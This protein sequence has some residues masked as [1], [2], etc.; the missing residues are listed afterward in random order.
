MVKSIKLNSSKAKPEK[1]TYTAQ[2]YE[3]VL[4]FVKG[5]E[6]GLSLRV[7]LE[8]GISRSELLGLRWEDL[9]AEACTLTIRQGLVEVKGPDTGKRKIIT[10]GLKTECRARVIP[11]T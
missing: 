10:D 5:Q 1:R 11:I 4:K 9:D 3:T 7:L 8:T 6:N 2:Q